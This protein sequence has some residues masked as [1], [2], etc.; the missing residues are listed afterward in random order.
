MAQKFHTQRNETIYLCKNMYANAQNN[1]I[2]NG[3]TTDKS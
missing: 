3:Q 2:Q 1:I